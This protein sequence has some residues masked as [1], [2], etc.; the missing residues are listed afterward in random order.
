[1]NRPLFF[2]FSTLGCPHSTWEEAAAIAK[3]HD[4]SGVELRAL[5]GRLDLPTLLKEDFGTPE[6]MARAFAETGIRVA[7]LDGSMRLLGAQED[8]R[9][10]MQELAPWADALGVPY[11]RVFDGGA[12]GDGRRPE[13]RAE[14]LRELE[15]W[16]TWRK[17]QGIACELMVE[18]HWALTDPQDC[19][20]LGEESGGKLNLLWDVCH[21]WA[22]GHVALVED[23]EIL[24]PWVRHIH[25]KDAARDASAKGGL[26]DVLPGHGELPVLPLLDRLAQDGYAGPVSLEWELLW[27]P[28]LP[29]LDEALEAGRKNRWW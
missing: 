29:T 14:L 18:T 13:A 22:S 3:R 12:A 5:R 20:S 21:T 16:T 1:M 23:W 15:A 10:E 17:E 11:L 9:R 19:R 26:R 27:H 6:N 7:S 8:H 25:L 2:T 28:E 24:K 4:F